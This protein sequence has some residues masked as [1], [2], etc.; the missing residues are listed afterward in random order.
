MQFSQNPVSAEGVSLQR[1]TDPPKPWN[2]ERT[3]QQIQQRG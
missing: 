1:K 2:V 3:F